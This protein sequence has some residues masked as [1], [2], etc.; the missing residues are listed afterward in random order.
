VDW[1]VT[2]TSDN[3]HVLIRFDNIMGSSASQVPAGAT[4]HA[5]ELDLGATIGNAM[6]DGGTFHAMLKPWLG[7]STWNSLTNGITADDVEAVAANSA[8]AGNPSLDPNA[9]AGFLSYE[10]T[11][12]VKSW[13]SGARP[14]YGWAIL[15]WPNGGGGW[16]FAT[17]EGATVRGRPNSGGFSPPHYDS[18]NQPRTQQ[19]DYPVRRAGQHRVHRVT[20]HGRD[21]ALCGDRQ[22][23]D[24]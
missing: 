17:S 14:N 3:E 19:C 13:V 4:V 22:R 6:G 5:A 23:L 16:G 12:D 8:V 2:G 24:R 20:R 7:T 18:F 15:P 10:L 9:Q 21:R 11:D 1:A